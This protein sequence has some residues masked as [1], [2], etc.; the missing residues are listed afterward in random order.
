MNDITFKQNVYDIAFGDNAFHRDYDDKEVLKKL[1][2]F[3]DKAL[4]VDQPQDWRE[5][6]SKYG[7]G[8]T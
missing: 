2:E 4:A 5:I 1:R 7:L 3:S 6:R 8:R